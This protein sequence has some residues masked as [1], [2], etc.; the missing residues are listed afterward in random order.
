MWWEWSGLQVD[1]RERVK[2]KSGMGEK[3]RKCIEERGKQRGGIGKHEGRI[4]E[5]AQSG[6]EVKGNGRNIVVKQIVKK[7]ESYT[8]PCRTK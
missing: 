2:I 7:R 1:R 6:K 4:C 8:D 5:K 3:G